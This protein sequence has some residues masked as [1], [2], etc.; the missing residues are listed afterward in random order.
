MITQNH[1]KSI[2]IPKVLL[3]IFIE[4]KEL[5]ID[6]SLTRTHYIY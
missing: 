2:V 1:M 3:L 5:D 4:E 6:S